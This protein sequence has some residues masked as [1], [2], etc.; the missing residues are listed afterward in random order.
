[1]SD[2]SYFIQFF[3]YVRC[4]ATIF[5]FNFMVHIACVVQLLTQLEFIS[6][7]LQ[8][9]HSLPLSLV[10]CLAVAKKNLPQFFKKLWRRI[11]R[12]MRFHATIQPEHDEP[13][14]KTN[15]TKREGDWEALLKYHLILFE[16]EKLI[17][18]IRSVLHLTGTKE[19][20]IFETFEPQARYIVVGSMF[21][22]K[23]IS[24]YT[25]FGMISSVSVAISH[26]VCLEP[27]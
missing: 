23:Y 20:K 15:L 6:S 14:K 4:I 21:E 27:I 24:K 10:V 11:V 3:F 16:R 13:G 18:E 2:R 12:N 7:F 19:N 25:E 17:G 9:Y 22:I 26:C 5:Q 8:I 1:M